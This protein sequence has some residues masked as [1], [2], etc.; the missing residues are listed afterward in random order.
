[1][2]NTPL[3]FIALVAMAWAFAS[4]LS[5]QTFSVLHHFSGMPDGRSPQAGVVSVGNALFGAADSGGAWGNGTYFKLNKDG[6]GYVTLYNFSL[7]LNETNSDGAYPD[8]TPV[9]VGNTLFGASYNGGL[10]GNGT[11]FKLNTNGTGF[12]TLHHFADT[13]LNPSGFA[14]NAG[15]A[16]PESGLLVAD[17]VVYGTTENGGP[18]GYGTVFRVKTDGTGFTNLHSFAT[19]EGEFAE[20]LI[21]VGN[22]LYGTAAGLISGRGT[23]FKLNTNGSGFSIVRTFVATNFVPPAGGDGPGPEPAYPNV[24]GALVTSL[25]SDGTT[26]FGTTYCGG[27]NGNGTVFRMNLDGSGFS[28]L[29]NFAASAPNNNG[30]YTNAGGAHPIQFS[31]LKLSGNTL[32]GT[33]YHG[34]IGGNGT[35]FALTTNGTEFAVLHNFST[36]TGPNANNSDGANPYQGLSLSAG[37]LFGTAK[38][39]GNTGNG[40]VF[41]INAAPA[42]AITRAN[43]SVLLTWPTTAVGFTL[44]STTNLTTPATWAAVTP[45]PTLVNGLNTVTNAIAISPK[46][47]RLKH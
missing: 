36:T 5:A 33:T 8:N 21:L 4:S 11:V 34:G 42:L 24:D 6:S 16:N 27:V 14:T 39:G 31:G 35:V 47:Y 25:T 15:G 1:M 28:V 18:S 9:L 29:H 3:I 19:N 44:E 37:A 22:N 26:L 41:S 40:T 13:T 10:F 45:A 23:V 43:T 12:T 32:Y 20:A 7:L 2:K 46:F 30:S 17:E 38:N